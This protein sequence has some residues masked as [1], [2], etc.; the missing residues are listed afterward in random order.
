MQNRTSPRRPADRA[1]GG[2]PDDPRRQPSG[3]R[4]QD[5]CSA[6]PRQSQRPA[7]SSYN[8]TRRPTTQSPR[9]EAPRTAAQ[10]SRAGAPRPPYGNAKN[11]RP[12]HSPP[13]RP[14]QP[15]RASHARR[16][17][18]SRTRRKVT[19][20]AACVLAVLIGVGAYLINLYSIVGVGEPRFVEN[21]TIDGVSL[22]GMTKEA[23]AAYVAQIEDEWRSEVYT[24]QYQDRT[25]SFSRS[26]VD[27]E[28]DYETPLEQAWNLGQVGT[29]AQRKRRILNLRENPID[30]S[31]KLSYDEVKLDEYVD[32]ICAQIDLEPVNAVIVPDVAQPVVITPS[33][34]GLK[35][36]RE[37]LREQLATLIEV[38]EGDTAVPVETLF[39]EVNSDIASFEIIGYFTT[40]V[41]FRSSASRHNVRMALN[42]FNGQTLL[43]GQRMSFNEVVGPRTEA[44]GFKQATEYVGD[45]TTLGWG[46][47]VCQASTTLYNALIMADMTIVDRKQ[48]SMTVSYVD[49]SCDAAVLY[50][51]DDL[52]FENGS[53]YPIYIYTSVTDDLATVTIYG[54]KPEYFY[55][56]ES[57][58]VEEDIPST[59]I[60][61]TDDT[62]GNFVYY[63]DDPPVLQSEGK[64]GCFT[65]GWIVAYD[66]ETRQ[67]VSRVQVSSD[68]YKPSASVYYRGVHDRNQV[69]LIA[70]Y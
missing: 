48:H 16:Q 67:E 69:G 30:L 61:Y 20:I 24:I 50:G 51:M 55:K 7:A 39:P 37:Q 38:G 15:G 60:V 19:L 54:H 57:V 44:T 42:A 64:P 1:P 8:Q 66:W 70:D 23:G 62:S 17:F 5:S 34:T 6:P 33:S 56:L 31:A 9:A 46:G 2:R 26:M 65:Q 40:D 25:W 4:R 41:S 14:A 45:T 27:A 43:P 53:E 68:H 3:C 63:K 58:V 13:R 35:V 18:P 11:G 12:V 32:G 36:N 22:A 28:I 47:G 59:R 52:V 10:S 29:V 21:I 49:P